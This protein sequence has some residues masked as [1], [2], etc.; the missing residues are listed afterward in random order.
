MSI[1]KMSTHNMFS[2]RNKEKYQYFSV[3][4]FFLFQAVLSNFFAFIYYKAKMTQMDSLLFH[5][6]NLPIKKI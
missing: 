6:Y 2:C 1:H 4:K 3:K 5:F